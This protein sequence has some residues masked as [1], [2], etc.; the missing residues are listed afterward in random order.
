MRGKCL[1][2]WRDSDLSVQIKGPFLPGRG[3]ENKGRR[4]QEGG[5]RAICGSGRQKDA[6]KESRKN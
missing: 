6:I 4:E 3:A 2:G 1:K 5:E